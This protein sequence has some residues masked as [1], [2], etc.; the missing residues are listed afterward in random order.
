MFD[1]RTNLAR[2]VVD[3][4][5]EVFGAQVFSTV[6]PR[7][8]RLSEAP[9]HGQPIFLYDIRSKGAEAYL[10]LAKEF[11]DHETKG[12]GQRA[13][14]SDPARTGVQTLGD[15]EQEPGPGVP[16]VD[17][18]GAEESPRPAAAGPG[19]DPAQ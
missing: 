4:V 7:N 13:E 16:T 6:I 1:E 12:L 14:E 8:V 18:P 10:G 11:L 9:S 5:R 19:P 17:R 2:Q 3:E 15:G